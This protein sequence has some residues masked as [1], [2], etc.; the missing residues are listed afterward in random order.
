MKYLI[1]MFISLIYSSAQA[2]LVLY[3]DRPTATMA[4]VTE[5]FQKRTGVKTQ[6]VELPW[7][8]LKEKINQEGQNS[9]ADVILVKDLVFLNELVQD[10]RLQPLTSGVVE[11]KVDPS[12]RNK[13]YTAITYRART[14]IHSPKVDVSAINSYADL[15]DPKY[16]GTLC[17]RTSKSAYNEALV[18][19]LINSYGYDEAYTI[20]EGWLNNLTDFSMIYPNDNAIIAD[21]AAGKCQLGITNTY[22]LGLALQKDPKLAVSVKF[23]NSKESGVHTNG[24]GAGIS[25]TSTQFES[26]QFIEFMLTDEIQ[27]FL[28]ETQQDFPANREVAFPGATKTWST[29]ELDEANWSQLSNTVEQARQLFEELDYQ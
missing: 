17:L 7:A 19:G 29:F 20:V 10:S 16:S 9:P 26:T 25:V 18:A 11:S 3:T 4:V 2:D 22:Y 27:K 15:A 23:L 8:E 28:T 13:F 24:I 1:L 14:L 12:M 21:I 5:A 6:I